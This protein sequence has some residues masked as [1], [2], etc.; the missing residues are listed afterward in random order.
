LNFDYRLSTYRVFRSLGCENVHL[1]IAQPALTSKETK[2]L[3]PA[4]FVETGPS[5]LASGLISELEFEEMMGQ[6]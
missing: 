5:L 1:C 2:C 3:W 4:F 6:P